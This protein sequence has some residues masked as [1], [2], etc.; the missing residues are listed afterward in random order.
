MADSKPQ[1]NDTTAAVEAAAAVM[2]YIVLLGSVV[3]NTMYSVLRVA[4]DRAKIHA[5]SA[6]YKPVPIFE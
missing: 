3:D 1:R 5:L 4:R 6:N 2:I